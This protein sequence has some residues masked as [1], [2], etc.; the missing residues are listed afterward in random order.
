MTQINDGR[1]W[2]LMAT[3]GVIHEAE[4]N[5]WSKV[6][7]MHRDLTIWLPSGVGS[8]PSSWAGDRYWSNLGYLDQWMF[9]GWKEVEVPEPLVYP[10]LQVF[11]EWPKPAESAIRDIM[12]EAYLAL[13]S[14]AQQQ[15][16]LNHWRRA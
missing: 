6:S 7:S 9:N 4:Q 8:F 2:R 14:V 5:Q 13:P 16:R 11:L 3:R 10:I 15:S 12:R 1:T